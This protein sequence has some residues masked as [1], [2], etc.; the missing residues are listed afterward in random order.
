METAPAEASGLRGPRVYH[1]AAPR[2]AGDG[3]Q[4]LR[5]R[6]DDAAQGAR[7]LRAAD[8]PPVGHRDLDR[9]HAGTK[10]LGL[11]F[12]RPAVVGVLHAEPLERRPA[13]GAEGTEV[14]RRR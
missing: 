6:A 10:R 9:D 8:P 11:H 5:A 7:D 4:D 1:T 3:P 13:D 12:D 2:L 14:G